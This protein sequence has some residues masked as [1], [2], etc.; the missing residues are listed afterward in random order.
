M[1]AT[2]E[3]SEDIS[4]FFRKLLEYHVVE[5]SDGGK[6]IPPDEWPVL[7]RLDDHIEFVVKAAKRA[8]LNEDEFRK[9]LHRVKKV[10]ARCLDSCL[11]VAVVGPFGAGKS[12]FI[13]T[14]L[15]DDFLK[16]S[17]KVATATETQ[18]RYS[19]KLDAKVEFYNRLPVPLRLLRYTVWE[20]MVL[21]F[22]PQHRVKLEEISRLNRR[23]DLE[24]ELTEFVQQHTEC[25]ELAE[26][27]SRVTLYHPSEFLSDGLV[28]I[29]TPGLEADKSEHADITRRVVE[30]VA[31]VALVLINAVNP[32]S[33]DLVNFLNTQLKGLLNRCIFIVTQIDKIA[34]EEQ[35][36]QVK[37][38]R[39]RLAEALGY[40]HSD[41][42]K[43][44]ACASAK[45]FTY[46]KDNSR[47]SDKKWAAQFFELE[48]KIRQD[49]LEQKA[50]SR[51]SSLAK[52]MKGLLKTLKQ[53]L[54]RQAEEYHIQAEAIAR[55][56]IQDFPGFAQKQRK[57]CLDIL[58]RQLNQIKDETG[59]LISKHQRQLAASLD[60]AIDNAQTREDLRNVAKNLREE[61]VKEIQAITNKINKV[62]D[63]LKR[64]HQDV[65]DLFDRR[66]N[67]E[68][69]LISQIT[70]SD[71]AKKFGYNPHDPDLDVRVFLKSIENFIE[72][73]LPSGSWLD[74]YLDFFRNFFLGV[75]KLKDQFK[76]LV[77]ENV[78][79]I[80]KELEA[81]AEKWLL[82]EN[83][84]MLQSLNRYVQENIDQ[85]EPVVINA[86]K[87]LEIRKEELMH[88]KAVIESDRSELANRLNTIRRFTDAP[89]GEADVESSDPI[90]DDSPDLVVKK[91]E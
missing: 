44:Y 77:H 90:D 59:D 34:P 23:H 26:S 55:E 18:I 75:D 41:Q 78:K 11:Y 36:R 69:S 85:Y 6:V 61:I 29:D 37:Y 24:K 65:L 89:L 46:F 47:H 62:A 28:L 16:T 30:G 71:P 17:F 4:R 56:F 50:S 81:N 21:L 10:N 19:P 32:V 39:S 33:H 60:E 35:K 42:L 80:Y 43:V 88:L 91:E 49:L 83:K 73:N 9:I 57:H 74:T 68:Y 48:K 84:Q 5:K 51:I 70:T 7:L 79:E 1:V 54:E 76:V 31:D 58:D 8:Q 64:A 72:Q 63:R 52:L 14:L 66:L 22:T 27:V 87:N 67:D 13:N 25:G 82:K 20:L 15:R 3:I 40:S 12:T 86:K 2:A 53:N 38:I 45:A